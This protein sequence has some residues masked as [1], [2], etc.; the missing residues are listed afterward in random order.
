M[1]PNKLYI[2][3]FGQLFKKSSK[4]FIRENYLKEG[5]LV[6]W[7]EREGGQKCPFKN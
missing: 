1:V 5:I 4:T 6:I 2:F 3:Y 7:N